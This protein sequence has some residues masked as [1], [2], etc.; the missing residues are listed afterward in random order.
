MER[1]SPSYELEVEEDSAQ[2]LPPDSR[3]LIAVLF[4]AVRDYVNYKD[5][6]PGTE[7]H[8]I[9]VDAAGWIWWNGTEDMTFLKVCEIV[10]L[11]PHKIRKIT[12]SLTPEELKR[13]AREVGDEVEAED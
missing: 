12:A 2:E 8:K 13:M 6:K 10:G 1:R 4:R 7:R 3:L 9:A 11:N 5:A